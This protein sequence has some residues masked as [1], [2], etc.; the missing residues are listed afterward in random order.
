L[1]YRFLGTEITF[2]CPPGQWVAAECLQI[3]AINDRIALHPTTPADRDFDGQPDAFAGIK[4]TMTRGARASSL[5][6][7]G[8]SGDARRFGAKSTVQK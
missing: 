6:G 3:V 1:I 2:A 5:R 8:K 4:A 7:C